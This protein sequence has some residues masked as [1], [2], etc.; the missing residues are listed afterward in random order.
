MI[1]SYRMIRQHAL[2]LCYVAGVGFKGHKKFRL[3]VFPSVDFHAFDR[4]LNVPGLY[5]P[6]I[7]VTVGNQPAPVKTNSIL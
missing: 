4:V 5:G 1:V 6:D 3:K 7:V 2:D